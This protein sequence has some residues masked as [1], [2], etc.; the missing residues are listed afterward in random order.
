MSAPRQADLTSNDI[1]RPAHG[2]V[3]GSSWRGMRD[4][5]RGRGRG[6][7]RACGCGRVLPLVSRV[8]PSSG[9]QST[10]VSVGQRCSF[11]TLVA[12][13][14]LRS[15][16][17]PCARVCSAVTHRVFHSTGGTT[18]PR[19]SSS[20][21]CICPHH[22]ACSNAWNEWQPSWWQPSWFRLLHASKLV[23]FASWNE[24]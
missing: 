3:S 22:E 5:S 9:Q 23:P 24:W 14:A 1:D 18:P 6:R 19:T 7:G 20:A 17:G 10:R 8:R 15:A 13:A 12:A 11:E 21:P 4:L 2:V 16:K